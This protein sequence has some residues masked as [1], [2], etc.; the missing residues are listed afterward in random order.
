[1]NQLIEGTRKK[2]KERYEF[3]TNASHQ[4]RTP[5]SS[6]KFALEYLAEG[7]EEKQKADMLLE[8]IKSIKMDLGRTTAI[9]TDM[10]TYME[11]GGDYFATDIERVNFREL[12]LELLNAHNKEISEKNLKV[13][14]SAPKTLT[15]RVE[16]MRIQHM[17]ND[18]ISNA[19]SYSNEGGQINIAASRE[20]RSIIFTISDEGIGIPEEEKPHLFTKFFRARNSYLKKSVGSGLGLVN[21]KRIIEGHGGTIKVASIEGKGTTVTVTILMQ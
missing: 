5:I 15:G 1:M 12:L 3:V 10:L 21:A 13:N 11:L 6:V 2:E 20:K 17:L 7:I 8:Q 18:L 14:L 19:I 16:K 9:L 4:L